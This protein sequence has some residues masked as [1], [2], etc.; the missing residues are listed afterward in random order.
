M[1]SVLG[2]GR[3]Q[4]SSQSQVLAKLCGAVA[5]PKFPRRGEG[6]PILESGQKTYYLARLCRK[7]HER[8]RNWTERDPPMRWDAGSTVINLEKYYVCKRSL[9][10][11]CFYTCLSIILFTGRGVQAQARGGVQ[12]QAWGGVQVQAQGDQAW[13][14]VSQHA[15]RQTPPQQ[16]ATAAD[17]THP[18]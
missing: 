18:T 11:L 5:D 16:T 7:L 1:Q 6:G 3:P 13:G 4:H 2:Q 17:G 8:E 12:A 14:G 10:R 9:R 15:L